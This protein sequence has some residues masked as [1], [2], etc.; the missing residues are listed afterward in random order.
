MIVKYTRLTLIGLIMLGCSAQ[1]QAGG[2]P[3][4]H[5]I[6]FNFTVFNVSGTAALPLG[7]NLQLV[8]TQID[9]TLNDELGGAGNTIIRE[10]GDGD[11]ILE[12]GENTFVESFFDIALDIRFTDIDN[13]SDFGNF[14]TIID[15]EA[16][17]FFMADNPFVPQCLVTAGTFGGCGMLMAV[18]SSGDD[19]DLDSPVPDPLALGY[20][21]NGD[22]VEDF[23]TT[24]GM[25]IDFLGALDTS[26]VDGVVTQTYDVV[27][28]WSVNFNPDQN[29]VLAGS[30]EVEAV[31][32]PAAVWL[33]LSGLLGLTAVA[34]RKA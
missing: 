2:G 4:A 26:I 18:N 12:L 22:L 19:Y 15:F 6:D 10:D 5:D 9:I 25:E 32:V 1:T 3:I 7:P 30:A 27:L 31:P 29:I 14:Q 8:N 16:V 21:I 13:N 34:R 23:I 17:E 20:D 24:L 33:F 28:D 11:L